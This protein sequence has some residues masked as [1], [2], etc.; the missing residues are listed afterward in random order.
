MKNYNISKEL[1]RL[2]EWTD[3]ISGKQ[4]L[5]R[6]DGP[7]T[8]FYESGHTTHRILDSTGVIHC[9]PA[10]GYFGCVLYW[11]NIDENNPVNF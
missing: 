3:P 9:I 10:V 1:Y 8:L 5:H 11:K 2:Y 4:I 6:I 7:I